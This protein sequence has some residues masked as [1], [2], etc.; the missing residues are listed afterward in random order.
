MGKRGRDADVAV[1]IAE[2]SVWGSP[3]TTW[4]DV[5]YISVDLR[6]EPEQ[7]PDSEEISAVGGLEDFEIG[8]NRVTGTLVVK[9]RIDA[10]WFNTLVAHC[11]GSEATTASRWCD[12]KTVSGSTAHLYEPATV[13]GK[14]LSMRDIRGAVASGYMK[15]ATGIKIRSWTWE[16][17]NDNHPRLS[18]DLV[19]EDLT[20][21]TPV[22]PG[23]VAGSAFLR[24]RDLS[25]STWASPPASPSD[26][27]GQILFRPPAG[28]AGSYVTLSVD[29]FSI[30]M[31]PEIEDPST[32]L[33][34][35]DTI[36]EPKPDA[37]RVVTVD[38]E[39]TYKEASPAEYPQPVHELINSA[40]R[41]GFS[42]LYST[43]FQFGAGIP[44]A[45]RITVPDLQWTA[46]SDPV[47]DGGEIKWSASGRG[48][49]GGASTLP[50]AQS[51]DTDFAPPAAG[52]DVRVTIATDSSPAY[53]I[54]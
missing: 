27:V 44:Y 22:S 38:V 46:A 3:G 29:S 51:G 42:V 45:C 43:N 16:Q 13:D 14:G 36:S 30:T 18:M 9:P 15:L 52:V 31:S 33:N 1:Q 40:D 21:A 17:P 54:L 49:L 20:T 7:L 35:P 34:S 32:D 2:E 24:M 39:G 41:A 6:K 12:N 26:F 23:T 37:T 8:I 47:N 28:G 48:V 50:D 5:P 11:L 19:G 10:D 25:R 53:S 4:L